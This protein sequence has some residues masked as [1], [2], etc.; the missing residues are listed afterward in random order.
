MCLARHVQRRGA[1]PAPAS[2]LEVARAAMLEP[3]HR[4]AGGHTYEVSFFVM[5]D[6]VFRSVYRLTDVLPIS[7]KP[8]YS[9]Y[10]RFSTRTWHSHLATPWPN[11]GHAVVT[12]LAT[13]WP[14]IGHAVATVLATP[15]PRSWPRRGQM[16]ATPWPNVGH[17]VAKC[18]PRRGQMLATPWPR[19]WPP[20]GQILATPWPRSW[21]P[22][23]QI[24]ATAWP[25]IGHAVAS[26]WPRSGQY[27][28][29]PMLSTLFVA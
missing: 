9:S 5:L 20:R 3:P 4:Q 14:D 28:L 19:S 24:L 27:S 16:L 26:I 23:G 2:H 21:P 25:N 29:S 15:W 12:V 11:I 18:W 10:L 17:A 8:N 7:R 22:R 1:S 13:P 6:T